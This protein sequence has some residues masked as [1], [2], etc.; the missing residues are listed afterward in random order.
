MAADLVDGEILTIHYTM[1]LNGLEC[2]MDKKQCIESIQIK[3]TVNGADSATINLTDPEFLFIEDNIFSEETEIKI[4]LGWVGT[5]DLVVFEGY[6]A[7]LDITFNDNGIPKLVLTCM[8]NTHIMNRV[9]RDATY[10][11]KKADYV[12][13][14]VAKR[15]G[16]KTEIQKK[17]KFEKK[18]ITQ[19]NQTDAEFLQN[20]ASQEV[21][22]FS[23]R[24]VNGTIYYVKKG[25]I[26]TPK[27]SLWYVHYPHEII[28]FSPKINTETKQIE[29]KYYKQLFK[30]KKV[31]KAMEN[32][33]KFGADFYYNLDDSGAT[34][35]N[36][37]AGR[38]Y[39]T[40]EFDRTN[41][42][43]EAVVPSAPLVWDKKKKQ[44][45]RSTE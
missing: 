31:R 43:R 7:S 4:E 1:W 19:S 35:N 17:Y 2:E 13:K 3:Q 16:F 40:V 30:K 39:S 41:Q 29:N 44:W 14:K 34:N 45:V 18:D 23:F 8:D 36:I 6:I 20:L 38:T 21:Y 26:G 27:M 28:S 22:P 5:T 11:K 12:V 24:L 25:E 10:K 42:P 9:K 37:N 33:A 32:A 15:Y